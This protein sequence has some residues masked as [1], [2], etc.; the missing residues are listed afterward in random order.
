MSD[1]LT[2]PAVAPESPP[3][4]YAVAAVLEGQDGA[5][6]RLAGLTALRA[7]FILPG[8]WVAAWATDTRMTGMQLLAYSL[9]G[10]TTI[11][12]GMLAWYFVQQRCR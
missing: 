12:L 1:G 7:A 10:S 6:V 9:A 2:T 5:L 11:S 3:S 4:T 8:F